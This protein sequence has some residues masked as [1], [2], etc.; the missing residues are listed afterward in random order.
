VLIHF[1]QSYREEI[2]ANFHSVL[3]DSGLLV[4]GKS[5]A[6]SGA[7]LDMFKLLDPSIKVYQ[8]IV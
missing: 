1:K 7:C 4:L 2:I 5:E 6:V 3:N 8:K